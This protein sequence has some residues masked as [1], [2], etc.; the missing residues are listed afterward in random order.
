MLAAA[1]PFIILIV[2]IVT[3]SSIPVYAGQQKILDKMVRVLQENITGVRVIR[4]LSRTDYER[5]RYDGVN[6][7]LAKI[8]QKAG[9]I[10]CQ[11][12]GHHLGAEPGTDGGDHCRRVSGAEG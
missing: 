3:K 7:E 11:R 12:S 6:E 5:Q 2:W 4:A 9:R 10:S 8:E 1:L